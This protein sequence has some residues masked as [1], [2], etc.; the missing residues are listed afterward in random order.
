MLG[1]ALFIIFLVGIVVFS[2]TIEKNDEQSV[3]Y[4][5]CDISDY[6]YFEKR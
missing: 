1:L 4:K 3:T 5:S 6:Q 2:R